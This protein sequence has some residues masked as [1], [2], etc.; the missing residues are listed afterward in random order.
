MRWR[1][2]IGEFRH[3]RFIQVVFAIYPVDW[4][5]RQAKT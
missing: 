4:R 5:E 3:D 1:Q 2:V